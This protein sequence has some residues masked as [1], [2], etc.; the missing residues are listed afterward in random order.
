MDKF[1][2][3]NSDSIELKG[4]LDRKIHYRS[5]FSIWS[6]LI[7]GIAIMLIPGW[8]S[9]I[10]GLFFVLMALGVYF[11]VPDRPT[12]DIYDDGVVV[13][14]SDQLDLAMFLPYENIVEFEG[15]N[16]NGAETIRFLMD[17]QQVI[18]KETFNTGDALRGLRKYIQPKEA[19]EIKR[20][21]FEEK[22]ASMNPF[23]KWFK[24][25]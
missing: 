11:Y 23:K 1:D 9:K 24:K 6:C 22:S 19:R 2:Y 15:N 20:K 16:N 21:E 5:N 7:A 8:I 14:H 12:L 10:L 13:Y 3:V 17:N 4:H 18:I 25:K